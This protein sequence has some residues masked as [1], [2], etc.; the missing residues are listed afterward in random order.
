MC[1]SVRMV[2]LSRS[3]HCKPQKTVTSIILYTNL[4]QQ[5]GSET[6]GF[7]RIGTNCGAVVLG[8]SHSYVVQ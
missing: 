8:T 3:S 6:L 1:C 4:V 5:S 7:N 2:Y